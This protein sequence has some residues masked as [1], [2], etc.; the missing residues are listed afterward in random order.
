MTKITKNSFSKKLA[1]YSALSL[2]IAGVANASGQIVY[3]DVDPD[4]IG[5]LG[6]TYAIDFD[7][8]GIIDLNIV[9][10]NNGAYE[11]IHAAP[12]GTNGVLAD[13]IGAYT[14][15]S[16]LSYGA[17]ISSGLTFQSFGDCCAGVGYAGSQF[18]GSVDAF[19]GVEFDLS[20]GTHYGWIRVDIADNSN[21]VVK[22]FAYESTAGDPINAGETDP[23]A[24]DDFATSNFNYFID[25]N[26]LLNLLA[27]SNMESVQLFNIL[28]QQVISQKLSNM[29]EVIDMSALKSGVYFAKV[30][31]NGNN[32]SFKLVKK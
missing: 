6:D 2:A 21:Y 27:A 18:C 32:K 25:T 1:K 13:V 17:V 28:G 10:S 9:Q 7:G 8:D 15:A 12:T 16:N 24:I 29:N 31:I 20:G 14:Y 4:F 19:F 26:S 3:T 30:T 11:I 5:G 23:L 22:D